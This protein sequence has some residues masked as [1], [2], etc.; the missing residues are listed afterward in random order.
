MFETI[1]ITLKA[2]G[3]TCLKVA[4]IPLNRRIENEWDFS[5]RGPNARRVRFPI[6]SEDR[7][8]SMLE[9]ARGYLPRW[10]VPG[11]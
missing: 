6:G 2:L 1:Q 11:K 3:N 8:V 10:I 7:G 9:I 4:K 5:I